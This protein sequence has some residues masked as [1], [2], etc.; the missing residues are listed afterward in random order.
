MGMVVGAC[1]SSHSEAEVG[2]LQVQGQPRQ[3]SAILNLKIFFNLF[4]T[5]VLSWGTL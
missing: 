1:N 4:F 2:R 3:L 5:I